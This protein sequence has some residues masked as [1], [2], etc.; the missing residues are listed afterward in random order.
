MKFAEIES[1]RQ[2]LGRGL[3]R[4]DMRDPTRMVV[5]RPG[6]GGLRAITDTSAV[7]TTELAS[8]SEG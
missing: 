1:N 7:E 3:L 5:R 4:F 2:L 6:P 8:G